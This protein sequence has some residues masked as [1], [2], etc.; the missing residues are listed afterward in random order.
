MLMTTVQVEYKGVAR[1]IRQV[2]FPAE[3]NAA[4][5]CTGQLSGKLRV[6]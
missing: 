4:A 2:G 5:L 1:V 6:C 3:H